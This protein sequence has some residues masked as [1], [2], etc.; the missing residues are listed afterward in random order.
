MHRVGM[1]RR[2]GQTPRLCVIVP[3]QGEG[4]GPSLMS[5]NQNIPDCK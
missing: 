2:G 1:G 4:R 3:P 5:R